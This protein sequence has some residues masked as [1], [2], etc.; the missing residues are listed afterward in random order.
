MPEP[1]HTV[2]LVKLN[3]Q[4]IA[5][6][7]TVTVM[8]RSQYGKLM[9]VTHKIKIDDQIRYLQNRVTTP[10][11]WR[12]LNPQQ[13]ENLG[14]PVQRAVR[15]SQHVIRQTTEVARQYGPKLERVGALATETSNTPTA[16]AARSWIQQRFNY[17]HKLVGLNSTRLANAE[18]AFEKATTNR[19]HWKTAVELTQHAGESGGGAAQGRIASMVQSIQ[20]AGSAALQQGRILLSRTA[21]KAVQLWNSGKTAV[22][23]GLATV[24]A[25]ARAAVAFGRAGVAAAVRG[26]PGGPKGVLVSLGVAAAVGLGGWAWSA[27]NTPST[28]E[29]TVPSVPNEQEA[30]PDQKPQAPPPAD[31]MPEAPA[32]KPPVVPPAPVVPPPQVDEEVPAKPPPPAKDTPAE[33][34]AD[35][36]PAKP[37][38]KPPEKPPEK[39]VAPPHEEPPPPP[40]VEKPAEPPP[41]VQQPVAPPPPPPVEKPAEPPPPVQPPLATPTPPPDGKPA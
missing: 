16:Q 19:Q 34:P 21:D 5:D 6:K 11:N 29:P 27:W 36:E 15:G 2:D 7:S 4:Q 37:P 28:P 35:E 9:E 39:P 8:E 23:Y 10:D 41:P 40:P 22:G 18:E 12:Q 33:R 25:A 13:L 17:L 26:V 24:G 1:I 14:E 30:P 3:L 38:A 31:E 20:N 32:D